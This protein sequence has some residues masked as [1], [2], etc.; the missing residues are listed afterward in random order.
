MAKNQANQFV[1]LLEGWFTKLP[2][3]SPKVREVIVSI[4]PWY[5][6][7][8]GA[9]GLISSI[10]ALGLLSTLPAIFAVSGYTSYAGYGIV[11]GIL[12]IA[13]SALLLAAFPGTKAKKMSG[14]NFLF[15]SEVVGTVSAV[16]AVSA[17]GVVFAAVG[18]YLIF[19]IKSYYK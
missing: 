12:G 1:S 8:F 13:S 9:L 7:I 16:I 5:A 10:G 18:F 15:W 17:V 19:Q 3:L 4:T 2:P 11:Y 14:W 6:L